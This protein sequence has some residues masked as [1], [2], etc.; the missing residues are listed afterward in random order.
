MFYSLARHKQCVM[1]TGIIGR[2]IQGK[3]WCLIFG[4]ESNPRI[5]PPHNH[6]PLFR[7]QITM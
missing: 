1:S 5:G 2:D 6:L 3:S 4:I 7:M